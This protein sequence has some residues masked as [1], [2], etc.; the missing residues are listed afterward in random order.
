MTT[1]QKDFSSVVTKVITAKPDAVFYSGYYAEAAP[2]AQ[3]LAN[4]GFTGTFLGPDGVKDDRVHQAGRRR[5]QRRVLHLPLRPGRADPGV[6]RRVQGGQRRAGAGHV[7]AGGLRLRDDP[8]QGDRQ[9]HQ[10]PGGADRLRQELRRRRLQ[11]ALQV[12]RHRRACRAAPST[13]TRSTA[14]RSSTWAPSRSDH[15]S[16][17]RASPPT[18]SSTGMPSRV[19]KPSAL[20]RAARRR[21]RTGSSSTSRR[22]STSS[23]TARSTASPTARSTRSSRWVTRSSTACSA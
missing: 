23:G 22:S 17:A 2:M 16:D 19:R 13:V 20:T 6:L 21:T 1:G 3:Q 10:G 15:P 4:K 11:Q 9:G 8:A 5:L 18:S 7:L 12:G 14:A